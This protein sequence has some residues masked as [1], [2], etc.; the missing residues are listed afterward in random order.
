MSN[1]VRL[2]LYLP[3]MRPVKEKLSLSTMLLSWAAMLVVMSALSFYVQNDHNQVAAAQ[4]QSGIELQVSKAEL[5]K[6]EQRHADF[7]PSPLLMTKLDRLTQELNGKRFLSQHLKGREMPVEQRY[8]QVM[9]DLA[10]L[11]SNNLWVTHM[12]FEEDK[13]AIN[14]F[15]LDA[16]AVP[17]WLNQLQ[18]SPYFSGKSFAL[19]DLKNESPKQG[20]IEFQISTVAEAQLSNDQKMAAIKALSDAEAKQPN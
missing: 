20:V 11:H 5:T 15:A 19:M 18:Q 12:R 13:V 16:M 10:R 14:G 7:K 4:K 6:L 3:S 2:N 8:S 17:D 9:T 1:K